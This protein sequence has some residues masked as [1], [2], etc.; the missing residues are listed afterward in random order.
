MRPAAQEP[1][2]QR[3]QRLQRRSSASK[4]GAATA[5]S[6]TASTTSSTTARHASDNGGTRERPTAERNGGQHRGTQQNT[7]C[8]RKL[9]TAEN[10]RRQKIPTPTP[11]PTLTL[12]TL[13]LTLTLILALTL[14][15]ILILILTQVLSSVSRRLPAFPPHV[16]LWRPW[17]APYSRISAPA[18]LL[19]SRIATRFRSPDNLAIS[20]ISPC[21]H[22]VRSGN[23]PRFLA[24][25]APFL[26]LA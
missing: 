2:D 3:L 6:T 9:Q 20:Q 22:H 5:T 10:S 19:L 15:L 13:T 21:D 16:P 14:A 1:R 26:S 24:R 8:S 11:T 4:T 17:I 7:A 25:S 18:A 12:I 23:M